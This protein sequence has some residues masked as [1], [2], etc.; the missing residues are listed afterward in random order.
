[1]SKHGPCRTCPE[2]AVAW[3]RL[4]GGTTVRLCKPCLDAWFDMADDMPNL[5]PR[6][7]GW[8]LRPAGP[9]AEAVAAWAR[10]PANHQ[11]VAAV[12]RLE[13]RVN[14]GWLRNFIA[15][16]QRIQGLRLVRA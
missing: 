8:L 12:L 13:A 11:D 4:P 7:W 16:E 14:P 6:I 3:I 10:N 1:V 9:S 5:E 2:P 15:R